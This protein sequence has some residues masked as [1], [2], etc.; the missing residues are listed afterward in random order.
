MCN[1]VPT[2]QYLAFSHLHVNII[3]PRC[4]SPETTIH[5]LRDCPWA[6]E[7]WGNSL[8]ILPLS[9]FQLLLQALVRTNILYQQLPW[10]IYFSFLC[11]H[12]WLARNECIFKN[13]SSSQ[14]RIVHK[15]IQAAIEFFYLANPI[16]LVRH[17]IPQLIKW[18][19]PTDPFTKLNTDGSV[20]DNLGKVGVGGLLRDS[21]GSWVFGFSLSMGIAT[22]NMA[23][24]GAVRQGLTLVWNLGFKFI[25]LE[26]DSVIALSWLTTLTNN[27]P[28]DVLPLI[29]D[30]KS[31]ME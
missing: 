2:S 21:S 5:L 12:S 25:Q 4:N 30:C 28:P 18:L 13:H 3:C 20:V 19:A 8:D 14:H 24:L 11:W 31:L 15:M 29:Y 22:N 17:G 27:F 9:F 23:E 7:L 16:K 10:N 1:Q 6:K 26:I